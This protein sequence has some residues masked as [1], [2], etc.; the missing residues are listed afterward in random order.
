MRSYDPFD[1][2]LAILAADEEPNRKLASG[3]YRQVRNP[4]ARRQALQRIPKV[5]RPLCGARTRAGGTCK[6]RGW[7]KSGHPDFPSQNAD[8]VCFST[9]RQFA[10][11]CG[12]YPS[13]SHVSDM[14]GFV[15]LL[16]DVISLPGLERPPADANRA[17]RRENP[18]G[19]LTFL[20]GRPDVL[21]N[22]RVCGARSRL[23][24]GSGTGPANP[25]R[26]RRRQWIN[27]YCRTDAH[28]ARSRPGP[29]SP[30]K[31]Q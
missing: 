21:F 2:I 16:C 4:Q 29:N 19:P 13:T 8:R 22:G 25:V 10:L 27:G 1:R 6:A 7:F 31:G 12:L 9:P 30:T 11:K 24:S 15:M 23:Q 18:S 5:Q 3:L 20:Y 26:E 28:P 17:G 14:G